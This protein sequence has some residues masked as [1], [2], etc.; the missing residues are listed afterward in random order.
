MQV[1]SIKIVYFAY[2][3]IVTP[4]YKQTN[5]ISNKIN[6]CYDPK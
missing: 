6:T 1:N 2:I 4:T 5:I 3:H